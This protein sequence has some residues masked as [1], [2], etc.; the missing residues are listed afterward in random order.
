VEEFVKLLDEFG[1]QRWKSGEGRGHIDG[2]EAT[3][4]ANRLRDQAL[5]MFCALEPERPRPVVR[6]N[7]YDDEYSSF[8]CGGVRLGE[9]EGRG[10]SEALAHWDNSEKHGSFADCR[11]WL[12]AKLEAAGF[13]VEPEVSGD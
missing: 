1:F 8:D 6:E 4:R 5:A 3:E 9:V 13:D 12:I 7:A 2:I 10:E 11:A